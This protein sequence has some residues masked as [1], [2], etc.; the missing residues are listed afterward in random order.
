[1]RGPGAGSRGRN[2]DPGLT[3]DRLEQHG[4]GVLV[5]RGRQRVGVAEGH[6]A[7]SGVYGPNP[8]R[9]VSSSEKLMI[10]VVRPWK[11]LCATTILL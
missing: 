8:R 1:M 7:E 6:R 10:V 2:D 5:D 9:A 11:L 4:N 3:L